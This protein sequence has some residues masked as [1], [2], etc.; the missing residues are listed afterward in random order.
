MLSSL[1]PPPP[2]VYHPP[3]LWPFS[4]RRYR[5]R[6]LQ[7]LQASGWQDHIAAAAAGDAGVAAADQWNPLECDS[8]VEKNIRPIIY[9]VS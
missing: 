8:E 5:H 7:R 6:R 2:H 1:A 4:H 9:K 3:D